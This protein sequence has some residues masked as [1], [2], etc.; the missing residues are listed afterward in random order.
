[1]PYLFGYRHTVYCGTVDQRGYSD[2]IQQDKLRY[3]NDQKQIHGKLT[4][5]RKDTIKWAGN[6]VRSIIINT[7]YK[8][9]R[10]WNGQTIDL[11]QLQIVK[12]HYWK[13]VNDNLQKNRNNTG[14]QTNHKYLLTGLLECV[15][16]QRNY[17]GRTRSNKRDNYYMCSS[18][19]YKDENC[20][21]RSINI[22]QLDNIIWGRFFMDNEYRDY[23]KGGLEKKETEPD[24]AKEIDTI[25]KKIAGLQ[26]ERKNAVQLAIKGI[27]KESEVRPEMDNI[28]SKIT[29][30]NIKLERFREHLDF[31]AAAKEKTVEINKDFKKIYKN[32]PYNKKQEIL[33]KYIKRIKILYLETEKAYMIMVIPNIPDYVPDLLVTDRRYQVLISIKTLTSYNLNGIDE[34]KYEKEKQRLLKAFEK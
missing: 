13:K 26:S 34:D 16:C 31:V 28:D 30:L 2:Q 27:L 10:N 25:K 23:L 12:P 32:T 19:R 3:D 17:Y 5:K 4:K 22:D 33:R 24:T 15:K 11:P 1:M 21:N 8:G 6:T 14:K 29:D 7:I 20:G 9:E 18:K